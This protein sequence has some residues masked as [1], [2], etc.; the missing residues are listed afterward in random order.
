MCGCG[1]SVYGVPCVGLLVW[2]WFFFRGFRSLF[3]KDFLIF[4]GFLDFL[5]LVSF[6]IEKIQKNS[7]E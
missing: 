5:F 1:V 6:K 2:A 4:F 3:F 7:K